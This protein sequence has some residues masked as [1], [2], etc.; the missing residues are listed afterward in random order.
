MSYPVDPSEV[1]ELRREV[2]ELKAEIAAQR[3]IIREQS[4]RRK[5]AE[6]TA[7]EY[8]DANARALRVIAMLTGGPVLNEIGRSANWTSPWPQPVKIQMEV[9][10]E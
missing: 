6:K 9:P 3:D 8:A 7:K 5:K 1:F 2:E 10:P 4:Q